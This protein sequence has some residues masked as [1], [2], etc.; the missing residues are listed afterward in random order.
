MD[1]VSWLQELGK[2][3]HG[4]SGFHPRPLYVLCCVALPIAW[5]LVV[6]FLLRLAESIVGIELGRGA[7]R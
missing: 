7:T 6:G 4:G 5:G 1:V 2:S 3:A